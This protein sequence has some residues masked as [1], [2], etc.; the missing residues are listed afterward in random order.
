ML[1]YTYEWENS[2]FK[3]RSLQNKNKIKNKKVLKQKKIKIRRKRH[4]KRF[5]NN[6]I[7]LRIL[8]VNAAGIKSKLQSFNQILNTLQPHIWTMQE[9]KLKNSQDMNIEAAKIFRIH[10]LNSENSEGGGLG[11]AM[12]ILKQ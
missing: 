9:T 1:I 2:F 3:R 7:K 11:K 12:M 5:E 8:G 6:A 10:Y 4:H